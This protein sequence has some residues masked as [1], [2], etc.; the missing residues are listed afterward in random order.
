MAASRPVSNGRPRPRPN[1]QPIARE[2]SAGGAK[3]MTK[4]EQI[5]DLVRA[6]QRGHIVSINWVDLERGEDVRALR[7]SPGDKILSPGSDTQGLEKMLA[8]GRRDP[9]RIPRHLA[10][11]ARSRLVR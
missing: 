6:I 10:L 1:Q 3:K 5:Q 2:G 11:A 8:K 4:E 9:V 7:T